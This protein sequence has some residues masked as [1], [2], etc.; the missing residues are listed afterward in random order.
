MAMAVPAV[1]ASV[2]TTLDLVSEAGFNVL[3]VTVEPSGLPAD[4]DQSTLTGE[5]IAELEIHPLAATVSELTFTGGRVNGTDTSFSGGNF[6]AS[7]NLAVTGLG[8]TV[9]TPDP[10]GV[11]DPASG[12]FDAG[13]HAASIDEGRTAGS[14]NLLGEA[15]PIDETFTPEDP[16]TGSATGTGSVSLVAGD[17]TATGQWFDVVVTIPVDI[18]R[19]TVES[20]Q[21]I[22]VTATGTIKAAG[23][24]E[25]PLGAYL[26]WTEE[27]GLPGIAFDDDTNG[28]GLANGLAWALGHTPAG[29]AGA[30]RP[31]LRDDLSVEFATAAGGTVAPVTVEVSTALEGWSDL[32]AERLSIG[33]NP[34]PTGTSGTL[35]ISPAGGGREF[36]RLRAARP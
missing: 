19:V 6:F 35:V 5:L 25:V 2:E 8:G 27:N 31:R 34:I 33:E 10:P 18:V 4:T 28:D 29:V 24:V 30:A 1:S 12:D 21:T 17:S 15:T 23:T 26:A 7:Y 11:V 3:S 14:A 36:L 9:S 22:T 16:V 32:P 13:Q 20:G